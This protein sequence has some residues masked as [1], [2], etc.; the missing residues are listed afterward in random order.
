M[1]VII[2]AEDN[3]DNTDFFFFGPDFDRGWGS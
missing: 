3:K 2:T 1:V